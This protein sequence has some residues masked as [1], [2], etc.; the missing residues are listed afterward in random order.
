MPRTPLDSAAQLACADVLHSRFEALPGSATIDDVR[1]WFA[2]SS[3]RKMAFLAD[4]DCYVGSLT[5]ADVAAP[6]DP[7]RPAAELARPG[8]T[9]A[10]DAPAR[11][12]RELA[13]A[14]GALRVP[15]VDGAGRLL[16]VVAVTDDLAG[17]CG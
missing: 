12:G 14:G 17:F 1:Q 4:H 10:P 16:G 8:P 5:R 7:G 9:V 13:I 6:G 11:S 2:A 3:H 15:V